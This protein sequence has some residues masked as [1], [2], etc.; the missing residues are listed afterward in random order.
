MGMNKA[1]GKLPVLTTMELL[2][3]LH[4]KAKEL[5]KEEMY[6]NM[7][8]L[9][10]L[11]SDSISVGI[12]GLMLLMN[13][14]GH[15]ILFCTFKHFTRSISKTAKAFLIFLVADILLGYNSAKR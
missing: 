14:S 15:K 8:S 9:L 13:A 4:K 7:N 1:T 5:H 2:V 10:H 6:N 11:I 3:H 12:L